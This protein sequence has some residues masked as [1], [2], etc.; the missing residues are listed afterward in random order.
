MNGT[1]IKIYAIFLN[2]FYKNE[3]LE[4]DILLL[5]LLFLSAIIMFSVYQGDFI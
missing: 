1:V 2:I 5:T 4:E 3:N